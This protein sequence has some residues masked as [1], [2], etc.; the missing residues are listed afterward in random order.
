MKKTVLFLSVVLL[1]SFSIST[2]SS[3]SKQQSVWTC[4]SSTLYHRVAS[5]IDIKN[6]TGA[7]KHITL[8]EAKKSGKTACG[9][10]YPQST[11]KSSNSNKKQTTKVKKTSSEE[12]STQQNSTK[13][14]ATKV[15][16]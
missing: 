3:S 7:K 14:Q 13:K 10:C 12:T 15:K 16:K 4:S 1:C 11:T 8:D 2:S 6:C 5:C 9:I